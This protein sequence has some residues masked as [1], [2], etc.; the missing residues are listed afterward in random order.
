MHAARRAAR[1]STVHHAMEANL[2]GLTDQDVLQRE[3]GDRNLK[4]Y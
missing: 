1:V 2:D 3:I 4:K